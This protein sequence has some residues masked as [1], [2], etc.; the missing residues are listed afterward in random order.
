MPP[1]QPLT[2]RHSS[3]RAFA[4]VDTIPQRV[5]S[6]DP[7]QTPASGPRFQRGAEQPA[8]LR[9]QRLEAAAELQW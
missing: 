8:Q 9:Q 5:L 2:L 7:P 4:P 6:A 3:G 1:G